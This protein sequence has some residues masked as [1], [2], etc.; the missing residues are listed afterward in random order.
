LVLHTI[1]SD[2]GNPKK[3]WVGI[4]AAGVFAVIAINDRPS[5][6]PQINFLVLYFR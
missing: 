4:S 6:V 2:P 5:D 1:V 3:L